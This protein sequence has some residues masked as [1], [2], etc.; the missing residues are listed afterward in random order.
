VRQGRKQADFADLGKTPST[1]T[2][3]HLM[4]RLTCTQ[5]DLW[6]KPNVSTEIAMLNSWHHG[7]QQQFC[8]KV[9]VSSNLKKKTF[10]LSQEAYFWIYNANVLVT[11]PFGRTRP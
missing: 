8:L 7:S 6:K 1:I 4:A 2:N 3:L 10:S 11:N 9:A 5:P